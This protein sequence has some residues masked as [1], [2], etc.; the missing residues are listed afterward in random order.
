MLVRTPWHARLITRPC[1][2]A[3]NPRSVWI[4]T[5]SARFVDAWSA[6]NGCMARKQVLS[7]R[8]SRDVEDDACHAEWQRSVLCKNFPY[9]LLW[10][11]NSG[12]MVALTCFLGRSQNV[13]LVTDKRPW[14]KTTPN[15]VSAGQLLPLR[16]C[17]PV[18]PNGGA[19]PLGVNFIFKGSIEADWRGVSVQSLYMSTHWPFNLFCWNGFHL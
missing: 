15:K 6:A 9:L 7:L 14:R 17:R 11:A 16:R 18:V 5:R 8:F 1:R 3:S 2:C 13:R 19:A 4:I 10:S 12:V